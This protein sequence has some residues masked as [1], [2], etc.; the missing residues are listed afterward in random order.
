MGVPVLSRMDM[1]VISAEREGGVCGRCSVR[2]MVRVQEGMKRRLRREEGRE[3][4]V[5]MKT[6]VRM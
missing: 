4:A 1:T 5:G 3:R 2:W 6:R